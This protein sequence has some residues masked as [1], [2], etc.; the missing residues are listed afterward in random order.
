M[1]SVFPMQMFLSNRF[2][3]EHHVCSN[4]DCGKL[5]SGVDEVCMCGTP[6]YKPQQSDSDP[7][8]PAAK[9][10]ELS[11]INNIKM[12]ARRT[13]KYAHFP[14]QMQLISVVAGRKGVLE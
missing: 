8:E 10:L 9:F 4:P 11:L 12:R 3:S 14:N 5:F 7:R 13:F 6:R 1:S 2:Y